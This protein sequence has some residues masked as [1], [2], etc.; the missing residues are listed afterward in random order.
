MPKKALSLD[1]A[2]AQGLRPSTPRSLEACLRTGIDPDE[3]VPRL[4]E[5]F[6]NKMRKSDEIEREAA[7]IRFHHFEEGRQMKIGLLKKERLHLIESGFTASPL[8]KKLA[9]PSPTKKRASPFDVFRTEPDEKPVVVTDS[10][11]VELEEKRFHA[12]KV[13]QEREIAGIIEMETKMAE[14]QKQNAAREAIEAKRK[15]EWEKEKKD[16]RAALMAAKHERE[17]LKKKA[18]DAEAVARRIRA[19][20][21]AEKEKAL[22]EEMRKEE[23]QRQLE[24]AEREHDRKLKAEQHRRETEELLQQQENK[25]LEN[26]RRVIEREKQA[27]RKMEE[28]NERRRQEA[29]IR[30]EKANQRIQLAL[31]QNQHVMQKKKKDFDAKQ[32]LAAARA[33]EVHKKEMQDLK[34][35][36]ERNKKEEE[37]R[38][39]RVEAARTHQ[40]ARVQT[41]VEKRS[42]LESHLD[43]VY[44]ERVKDR[45]L[46]SVEREM[47]LEEKKANV[48]RIKKV[49]EF[50]RLQTL[51]KISQE[52]S[53]SRMIKLKK[54]ALIEARKKIALE[55]LVR[56]HRIAEAVGNMRISNKW[57]NMHDIMESAMS[58]GKDKSRKKKLA[59]SK[60]A[61]DLDAAAAYL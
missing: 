47:T 27:Q 57:D 29:L 3:I 26:R 35:R 6:V 59:S 31:E 54:Q 38:V 37:I 1:E 56:K 20:R 23:K 9:S 10:T 12:M 51:I 8:S 15:A 42:Q 58:P 4:L 39:Q 14:I 55:S 2:V 17:I 18:E 49:E 61:S 41:I 36:A 19:K 34:A 53:R 43:V 44:H 60:S 45:A 33:M 28:A 21:E 52:D 11:M 50:N 40:Q 13:R 46:K 48:E 25:I 7:Q 30:R 24:M 5:D 22:L 16:R 32:A